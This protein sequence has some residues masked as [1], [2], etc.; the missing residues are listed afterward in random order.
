MVKKSSP[1]S[2]TD[3]AGAALRADL[4]AG[5]GSANADPADNI[6]NVSG[7]DPSATLSGDDRFRSLI[8]SIDEAFCVIQMVF[9]PSGTAVDYLFLETNAV[10]EEQTGL[11]N[12]QGRR[13]R[14]MLP[15]IEQHWIDTYGKVALTGKPTR[16]ENSSAVLNRW[17]S[18]YAFRDGGAES[19]RVAILF[20][21]ISAR[22]RVERRT[23]FL[24]TLSRNLATADSEAA[25]VT[26]AVEAVGRELS[27]DRCYFIECVEKKNLVVVSHN[28]LRGQS[29]TLEGR[30]NLFD[31]GGIEWWRKYSTANF[32]V[33]DVTT[34][35]VTEGR[36]ANY[37]SRGIRSYM[38][39]PFRRQGATTVLLGVTDSVV[40]AWTDD[41]LRMLEDVTARVWPLV[42][43]AR[44]DRELRESEAFLQGVMGATADCINVLD[45]DGRIQWMSENGQRLMDIVDFGRVKDT[46]WPDFC[47]IEMMRREAWAAVHAARAGGIGRVRGCCLTFTGTPKWWDVIVTPIMGA[48][49]KPGQILSVARDVTGV[50][51]VEEAL[52]RSQAA[53]EQHAQTLEARLEELRLAKAQSESSAASVAE[54]AERFRLLS[55]VVSLQFWTATV[56]GEMDYANQQ[57]LEYLGTDL[58]R[59]VV[60][61]AWLQ[62]VHPDDLPAALSAWQVSISSGERYEVKF[63][64]RS[65]MGE[66]R[67]FLVR[68]DALRGGDG[69]I[70][71]WFG[72]NTDIHELKHAQDAVERASRAKDDFLAAL[73]HELRTPLT[74]VLMTASAL[75]DDQRLP[76]EVREQLGMMERNIELEARLIDDLLDLTTIS[77]GKL[78]LRAARC[79]AHALIDL[80]VEIV[81]DEANAKNLPIERQYDADQP[82]LMADPARFQQV[83]WN[84]LR[85][86][87]KFTPPGGRIIIQTRKHRQQDGREWLCIDVTDTGIGIAANQ[88]DQIFRPF[89]QGD[90]KG[91]HRFGGL[92]LGLAIARAVV[93]LHGGRITARSDGLDRGAT[94]LVE[95]PALS[96]EPP[97]E[98]ASAAPAKPTVR[99][100]S[101]S[102]GSTMVPMRLLLVEDDESSLLTLSR[103]L[104]RDGHQ[105]VAVSNVTLALAAAEK[106]AFDLVISDIGLP[107]GTGVE[108]MEKLRTQHGLRGVALSGYGM[109]EDRART[110][111][112]GFLA[113]LIKP[114]Q[115]AELRRVIAAL[116]PTTNGS[117]PDDG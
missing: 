35:P 19:R 61:S 108:M 100:N 49:G 75:A 112:A 59:D 63:R 97:P 111:K 22:K 57:A 77:N 69:N 84:L 50:R 41:D 39:Q 67:W 94:F 48:N 101:I 23:E 1:E 83:V 92:G 82:M 27:A 56:S 16:F 13:I 60:G 91:A 33:E 98:S 81:R 54:S 93:D 70:I 32:A 64:L 106:Q 47:A 72:S 76:A 87:V 31:L 113:H 96:G 18:V 11:I 14:E 115:I 66:Y 51:E 42:L 4:P 104:G 28:W 29:P 30:Y 15:T 20:N 99:S 36:V 34:H 88:L 45:L 38:V 10:F 2:V 80:A 21:D 95:L 43:R 103:L 102:A 90:R 3:A 17:F 109:E 116:A 71:R 8:D 44:V 7:S 73:S 24:T 25:I 62:F 65:K 37:M 74:P 55:D 110:R 6:A 89:E 79:D 86:S 12:A 52:Q 40:R 78:Q 58:Q 53:I 85:N 26:L 114:I 46:Y 105:I 68:A 107:D 9:D 5:S 117:G